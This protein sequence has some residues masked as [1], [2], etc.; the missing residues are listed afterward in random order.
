MARSVTA[1]G[2]VNDLLPRPKC[3]VLHPNIDHDL[4]FRPLVNSNAQR[5]VTSV[6]APHPL[7]LPAE[8]QRRRERGPH[9]LRK[10]MKVDGVR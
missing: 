9:A 2:I 10:P 6:V 5:Y 7:G 8:A 4:F 3:S 1:K